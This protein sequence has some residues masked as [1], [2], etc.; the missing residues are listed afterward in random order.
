MSTPP[1]PPAAPRTPSEP[2]AAPTP[3][4]PT[5]RLPPRPDPR[6]ARAFAALAEQFELGRPPYASVAVEWL[7]RRPRAQVIEVG[8]G[9]GKLTREILGQGHAVMAVEPVPEMLAQLRESS[10]RAHAVLGRAEALPAVSRSVDAVLAAD[11]FGWFD[12]TAF[13]SEATR[14]L[15]PGGTLGLLWN[16]PDVRV[17]WVRRLAALL[18]DDHLLTDPDESRLPHAAIDDTGQFESVEHRS[19]RVWHRLRRHELHALV[20]SRPAVAA[21]GPVARER[22]LAEVD[23]L[24]DDVSSGSDVAMPLSTHCF[25]TAVLPWAYVGPARSSA[26][27]SAPAPATTDPAATDVAPDSDPGPVTEATGSGEADRPAGQ[28]HDGDDTPDR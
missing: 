22:L 8:A 26:R 6:G 5:L 18:G 28:A 25:R 1:R 16:Q 10:S 4:G 20:A 23:A 12:A 15:R 14:V 27:T 13:L 3:E 11:S 2:T 17:P 24:F 9:T 19:F 21:Q 7:V